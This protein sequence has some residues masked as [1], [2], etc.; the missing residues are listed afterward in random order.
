MRRAVLV[1]TLA[2]GLAPGFA[3]AA[4]SADPAPPKPTATTQVC[5][6]GLVFDLATKKCMTPESR[7]TTTQPA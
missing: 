4:G 7:P 1:L 2:T 6:E 3:F 5:A